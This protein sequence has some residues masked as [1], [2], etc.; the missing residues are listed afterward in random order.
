MIIKFEKKIKC[1]GEKCDIIIDEKI[2]QLLPNYKKSVNGHLSISHG[3]LDGE[4]G[5]HKIFFFLYNKNKFESLY[6]GK[7]QQKP[8]NVMQEKYNG[9]L[10]TVDEI[11]NIIN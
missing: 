2:K 5:I 1:V 7:L 6:N 11:K 3:A 9:D 10:P 4:L 8:F